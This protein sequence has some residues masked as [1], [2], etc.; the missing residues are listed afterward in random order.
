MAAN[1]SFFDGKKEFATALKPAWHDPAGE[2]VLNHVPNSEEMIKAAH[3]DWHVDTRPIY[4]GQHNLIEG[5]SCTV[6][7]DTGL[8]LGIM[9]DKYQVVQN[10]EAFSFLD[11]LLQDGVMKY[12]SA[13]ALRGGR[14]IW[15]LGRLPS[16][17]QI[18][19]GDDVIRY[20]LWL[21]SHDAL[22]SLFCIPTSVRVVCANTAALAISGKN[23][24]RH[25][26]KMDEKLRQAHKVLSQ[27][28]KLFT[29]Y[30]DNGRML[31][32][33]KYSKE[34]ANQ[35]IE[36]LIPTPEK[37][38]R[39]T[40]IRERKVQAVRKAFASE[41]NQLPSIKGTWWSLLNSVTEAVDHH[42]FFSF[43]GS[44]RTRLERRMESVLMGP[45]AEFKQKAFDL[46]LAMAT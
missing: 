1:I 7:T 6:R 29:G 4:D 26:G 2:C 46:A 23:G 33:K 27:A 30:A 5:Y 18:A 21:N 43:K 11:S 8:H 38:G 15:A 25:V 28:D 12:E 34:D 40:A 41:R 9:S 45:G 14:T 42:Q 3:L 32:E 20:C 36:T 17:D 10:R 31:A 16:V 24:I 44:G 39:S 22:G 37:E 35:Y 13:G 19:E